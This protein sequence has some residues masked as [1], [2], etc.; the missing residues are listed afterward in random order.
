[1]DEN[2]GVDHKLDLTMLAEARE[3]VANADQKASTVL[4]GLGVGV[5]AVIGGFLAG[6]WRPTELAVPAMVLWWLGTLA[7]LAAM[8]CAAFAVWPRYDGPDDVESV[9]SWAH[10]ASHADFATFSAALDNTDRV[11][12]TRHQVWEISKI[13][14]IKCQL[15]RWAMGL[16]G[17][18]FV[19]IAASLIL[20]A[21]LS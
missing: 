12:R 6:D 2:S 15:V 8:A 21:T 1:M 17:T 10:V 11:S 14:L 18:T 16:A 3:D 19:L 13:V 20:D 4:A 5:G 9:Y 7:V